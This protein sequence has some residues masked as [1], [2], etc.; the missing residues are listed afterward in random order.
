MPESKQLV[1]LVQEGIDSF[2]DA[3]APA[4]AKVGAEFTPFID[5]SRDL[6]RGGKRFRAL[7]C[8]WG[9]RAALPSADRLDPMADV[10]PP[11]ETAIVAAAV[12][13][14]LFQ[15]AALVHDDIIDNS[16]TRRG[17]PSVHRRF[18]ATHRDSDWSGSAE[19]FGRSAAILLG[20]LLLAWSDEALD[21]ALSLIDSESARKVVRR[22]FNQM[23]SEVMLGQYLDVLDERSW[24]R[25]PESE[26]LSRAHRVVI[27]KSAR[28]SVEAPLIIGAAL[29]GAGDDVLAGLRA[30][31]L[32]L[33]I[34]FQL[35]D[36]M[37]G[38]FGDASVTGKPS[39]D[40][41]R[42]GKRTVLIALARAQLPSNARRFVDELLGDPDLSE[43]QV[44]MLQDALRES[45][46][47]DDVE[48]IIRREASRAAEA[49][50]GIVIAPSAR[51]EL[52]GLTDI[53][54]RRNA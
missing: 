30:Y 36:D 45:G 46:A 13:L 23:R 15:A 52:L 50:Q 3:R 43:V 18:E 12:A 14:E 17:G 21:E 11:S 2:L 27:H 42:E 19:A 44:R 24:M 10:S 26:Q 29:G 53:V 25:H 35:R 51:E 47:V 4:L 8:Y 39:G 20:D 33:G 31:G 41:L 38:V 22:E 54:V 40:D 16:N 6:L 9:W 5:Y 1:D 37:L 32:P 7:F 28:Y 34:A 48:A 49:L